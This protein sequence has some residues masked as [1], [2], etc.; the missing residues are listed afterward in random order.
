MKIGQRGIKMVSSEAVTK[1]ERERERERRERQKQNR[2][3]HG[4]KN[5][6]KARPANEHSPEESEEK[7]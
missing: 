5:R 1:R 2:M 4:K 3:K 7:E 6:R